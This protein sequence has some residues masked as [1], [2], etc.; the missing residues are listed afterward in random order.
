MT[1]ETAERPP[2]GHPRSAA[3]R[4]EPVAR[5]V[6]DAADDLRPRGRRHL[7]ERMRQLAASL[8]HFTLNDIESARIGE[9]LEPTNATRSPASSTSRR[10]TATSSS[11]STATSSSRWWRCCSAATATEPPVE[12]ERAFSNIEVHICAASVRA[13]GAGDAGRPSSP[14]S[15]ARVPLRA[16]RDADGFRRHR[17][18]QQSGRRR[19]ASSCR[20][21]TVAA[22]CSSSYRRPRWRLSAKRLSR[23]DRKETCSRSRLGAPDQRR[24]AADRGDDPRR[25]RDR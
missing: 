17:P 14:V 8:P 13:G 18:P 24:G 20:R 5:P 12:D 15:D 19:A 3:R 9:V 4:G 11:A 1:A 2:A 7:V 22:R 23:V 25:A 10:G 21:S 16:L 6:A